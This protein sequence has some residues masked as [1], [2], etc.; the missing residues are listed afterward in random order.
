MSFNCSL[1]TSKIKLEIF[2]AQ[3]FLEVEN[4]LYIKTLL[5]TSTALIYEFKV[6]CETFS[7]ENFVYSALLKS[8]K[9]Y[10]QLDCTNPLRGVSNNFS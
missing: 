8:P 10:K 7:K 4:D 5:C 6:S 9:S 3:V 2:L 1:I